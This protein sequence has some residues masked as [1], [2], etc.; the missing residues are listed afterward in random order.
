MN[1]SWNDKHIIRSTKTF[2]KALYFTVGTFLFLFLFFRIG[3]ALYISYIASKMVDIFEEGIKTDL[4]YL[5]IQGNAIANN[6]LLQQH[7]VD[8]DSD[9]LI[10]LTKK[11]VAVRGVGLIGVI[12]NEGVLLS[13]TKS[14]GSLGNNAFLTTPH[15]R[16]LDK[17]G[18][19]SSIE[20]SGFNPTQLLMTTGRRVLQNGNVIGALFVNHLMDD[21]YATR[22][23]DTYLDNGTEIIF[24]TKDFGVYGNSFT[25]PEI[26]NLINSYFNIGSEWIQHGVS[27]KTITLKGNTYYLLE[28]IVF[29]GLEQSPGGAIVFVPRYD[30]SRI[31]NIVVVIITLLTFIFLSSR[32][33]QHFRGEEHGCRYYVV[34][35]FVS[36]PVFA[37]TFIILQLHSVGFLRIERVPHTPYNSTLRIQ[38]EFGV[39]NLG[40]EQKFSVFVDTGDESVNAIQ[41]GLLFDPKAVEVK[42]LEVAT[43]TCSYI[44]KN[45]IDKD[46]GKIDFACAILKSDG[47]TGSF[48]VVDLIVNPLQTGTFS[49]TFDDM[50]TQ[51]LAGDGLGTNVLR[52]A[53]A[54]SYRVADF[55]VSKSKNATT[56]TQLEPLVIFSPTHPNKARW[57]NLD[58]ASFV[59]RGKTDQVYKYAF[60][61]L[62]DT[63]PSKE[64]VQGNSI[65]LPISGD[66]VLYFHLQSVLGGDIVHYRLQA[67]LTPPLIVAIDTSHQTIMV[68][69]VVRFSF[70]AKDTGSGVQQNYYVDLGNRLFLPIGPQLFVPFLEKGKQTVILRVYD[71]AGNY[72]EKSQVI[73]VKSH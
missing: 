14:V 11:E 59:W 52:M 42:A 49:L 35:A 68:G 46:K 66:G 57:Y 54:G 39:Y 22:F 47:E 45:Q 12:N 7:L 23:R 38:P 43:S 64:Y 51:V 58:K 40:F 37:L 61:N 1:H 19:V 71:G 67:D 17:S 6:K 62:S 27:G 15:G 5:K 28:N 65:T 50:D 24:Y 53:Q 29:S 56:T 21:V 3:G 36:L 25:D 55:Y 30:I 16:E 48:R 9:K 33:H 60:D 10:E 18:S 72:S 26:R 70:E 2:L 4:E 8:E 73:D 20:I 13:R 63:V 69:D 31:T 34:F 44:I 41:I 32:Y